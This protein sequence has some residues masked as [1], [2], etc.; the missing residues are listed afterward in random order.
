MN[1]LELGVNGAVIGGIIALTKVLIGFDKDKKFERYYPILPGILGIL[2][3]VFITVPLRW[4]EF[5]KNSMIY[6][7]AAAY[8][9]KL[10]KT[11]VFDK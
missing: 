3:A 7:P 11:T 10:G 1:L 6:G 4:Q 8:I 5:G 2:A 9:Y